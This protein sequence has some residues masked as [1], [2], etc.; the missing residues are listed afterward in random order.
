[1]LDQAVEI[2]VALIRQAHPSRL[3]AAPRPS[4]MIS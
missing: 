4:L 1:V 3:A 2:R